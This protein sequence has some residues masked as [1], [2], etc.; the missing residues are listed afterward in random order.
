MKKF[1]MPA[2]LAIFL[3]WLMFFSDREK[4]AQ[5]KT[6]AMGT[7]VDMTLMGLGGQTNHRVVQDAMTHLRRLETQWHPDRSAEDG[8]A[9]LADMNARLATAETVAVPAAL[10]DGFS[11]AAAYS[12]S[13]QGLFDPAVGAVVKLWGFHS[14]ESFPQAAPSDIALSQ[15][16]PTQRFD[17]LLQ[18]SA[19]TG[20]VGMRL[21]FGAF[22]KGLVLQEV[23]D[24][25]Q[26]Q[27]P[28][29]SFLLNGGG[30][31][32]AVGQHPE[33]PWRIAIRHPRQGG[34]FLAL[35][36]LQ[37]GEAAFTSGDYERYFDITNSAGETQHL[38]H[39]L[40]PRTGWP[41]Q[42]TQSLTV[43]HADAGLADAA[44]T[45]LFVAGDDWPAVAAGMG[46]EAVLRVAAD[47]TLEWTEAMA[48]RAEITPN[49]QGQVLKP[50]LRSLP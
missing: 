35:I 47:G 5:V 33:R 13:S 10:V 38:H 15:V 45:A 41:A 44:S 37:D 8:S 3:L 32:V 20:S 30:D 39:I 48:A 50:L 49:G 6:L 42:G 12:R 43:L 19:I 7:L 25:V 2:L 31:L 11:Q 9:L 27:Y 23:S 21:D 26:A 24:A 29:A 28:Q 18:Q 40:D 4:P 46:V 22:A 36:E 34:K 17:Q 14:D 16:M 1:L